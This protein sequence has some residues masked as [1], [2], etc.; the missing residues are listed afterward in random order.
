VYWIPLP[1]Y[2]DY[3]LHFAIGSQVDYTVAQVTQ[4]D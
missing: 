3:F 4:E 1:G 2:P